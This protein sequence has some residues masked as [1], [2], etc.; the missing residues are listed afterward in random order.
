MPESRRRVRPP[1]QSPLSRIRTRMR[2]TIPPLSRG[3]FAVHVGWG[4]YTAVSADSPPIVLARSLN[5]TRRR[6]LSQAEW[7][8]AMDDNG[9]A[10]VAA[11]HRVPS[12]VR[13]VAEFL[14][15]RALTAAHARRVTGLLLS[16]AERLASESGAHWLMVV[17]DS[18]VPRGPFGRRGYHAVAVEPTGSWLQ[19][20]LLPAAGP[21][22][23]TPARIH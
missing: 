16:A 4:G 14:L 6:Y 21:R 8:V 22:L 10:G 9:P 11:Y 13:L 5:R 19:K 3:P 7:I 17:L 2:T 15:D 18:D 12:Q 23:R 20:R 1:A